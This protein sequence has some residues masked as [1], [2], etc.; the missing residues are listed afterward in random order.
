MM[1][2]PL[3]KLPGYRVTQRPADVLQ[4]ELS[5]L[6][7]RHGLTGVVL[8][9]FDRERV[10]CRSWGVTPAMAAEMD[11]IGSRVLKDIGEGRHDPLEHIPTEG[12][13]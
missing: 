2:D 12:R 1:G 7:K 9:Q 3:E 10:G 5:E 11:K 13:A 6:A 8:I 4:R